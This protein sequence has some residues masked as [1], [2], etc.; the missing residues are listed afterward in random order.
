MLTVEMIREKYPEPRVVNI[1][2]EGNAGR[3]YCVGGAFLLTQGDDCNPWPLDVDIARGLRRANPT[4]DKFDALEI[5]RE[6]VLA[7]DNG[8]FETAW[9]LLGQALSVGKGDTND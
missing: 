8:H 7:N 5:A 1:R 6:I 2:P 9:K 3:G 4:L